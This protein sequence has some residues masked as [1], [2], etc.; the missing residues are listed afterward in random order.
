MPLAARAANTTLVYPALLVPGMGVELYG[1]Q[2]ADH[3]THTQICC[4]HV[5][6]CQVFDETPL[7]VMGTTGFLTKGISFSPFM[8]KVWPEVGDSKPLNG[9]NLPV[10]PFYLYLRFLY[11]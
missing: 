2:Q 1:S 8:R 4:F 7:P 11:V 5:K 10:P 3:Y 6:L 9:T